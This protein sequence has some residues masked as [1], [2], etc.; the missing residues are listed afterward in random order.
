MRL[1]LISREMHT[2][3]MAIHLELLAFCQ[4]ETS[5]VPVV[6][7]VVD[8]RLEALLPLSPA[9]R[10]VSWVEASAAEV[11]SRAWVTTPGTLREIEL[12]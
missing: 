2:E 11:G 12:E 4:P 7:V 9:K 1:G 5:S 8:L 10:F 6:A 3:D